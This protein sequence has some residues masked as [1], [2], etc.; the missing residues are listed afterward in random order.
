MCRDVGTSHGTLSLVCWYQSMR[1]AFVSLGL[2][3]HTTGKKHVLANIHSRQGAEYVTDRILL[4][5]PRLGKVDLTSC[6]END[7]ASKQGQ[8]QPMKTVY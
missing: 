7:V 3:V 1:V 6:P 8:K 5:A 4:L 2:R